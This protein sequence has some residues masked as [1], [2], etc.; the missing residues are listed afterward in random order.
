MVPV[1]DDTKAVV[2]ESTFDPT[3][4]PVFQRVV[5][6]VATF[7][8]VEMIDL[9]TLYS[10]IDPEALNDLFTPSPSGRLFNGLVT[11]Q[12]ENVMISVNGDGTIRLSD[13][14]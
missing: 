3:S 13:V 2:F 12:Y 1:D 9:D 14:K 11:F 4:G 6:A 8:E 7:Y 5:E 10:V